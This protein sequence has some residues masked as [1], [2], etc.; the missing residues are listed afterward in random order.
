MSLDDG[1]MLTDL[2]LEHETNVG[3]AFWAKRRMTGDGPPFVKIGRHVRYPRDSWEA[4]KRAQTFGSTSAA[5]DRPAASGRRPVSRRT[6]SNPTPIPET[7][8]PL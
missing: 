2:D 3:R 1:K 7:D 5:R 4:W 6:P 8:A